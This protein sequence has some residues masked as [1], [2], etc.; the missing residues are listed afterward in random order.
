[1]QI[2]EDLLVRA[3]QEHTQ[4]VRLTLMKAVQ[5]ERALDVFDVDEMIDDTVAVTG[6]IREL[7]GHRGLLIEPVNGHDREQMIDRPNVGRRLEQREVAIV[8][9][10]HVLLEVLQLLGHE[11]QAPQRVVDLLA[12]V[13]IQALH[14]RA[15]AQPEVAVLEQALGLLL[16]LAGVV[17]ALLHVLGLNAA[18]GVEQLLQQAVRVR[19]GLHRLTETHFVRAHDL[20]HQDR[21]LGRDRPAALADDGG[22]GHVCLDARGLHMG[23]D[24]RRVLLELIVLG[25][26]KVG[27]RTVVVHGKPAADVD[28]P[29]LTTELR[30]LDVDVRCFLHRIFDG[31]DARDLA[32]DVEMQELQAVEHLELAQAIHDLDDFGG[33][34][35][36]FG[37]IASGIRPASHAFGGQLGAHAEHGFDA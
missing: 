23:H 1:M 14:L 32:A 11:T 22:H 36:E 30:Q 4:I 31:N 17:V 33:G 27:L 20:E 34:E 16:G 26:V 24:V 29:H 15:L 5:V 10:G 19:L 8:D 3:V 28:V 21:V 37:A 12:A 2:A 6:Q 35:P 9:R 7:G 25:G 13:P 18:V